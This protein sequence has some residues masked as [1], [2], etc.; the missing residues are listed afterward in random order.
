VDHP[1]PWLKYVDAGDLS[2]AVVDFEGMDVESPDGEGLGDVE[3]FIVDQDNGRPY[4]VVVNS[5][6]WFKSK[7]FLLPVGHTRLQSDEG[8]EMLVAGISRERIKRFPGFDK[9]TFEKL[10]PEDLKRFNDDT[11]AACGSITVTYVETEPYTAAWDRADYSHPTWW[12]AEQSF[13][14][15]APASDSDSAFDGR[16][17][18]GD[19]VGIETDGERTYIGDT[20][21]DELKRREDAEKAAAKRT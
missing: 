14:G 7:H 8:G 18:P 13:G 1:Y 12:S 10:S 11:C 6:G 3:G 19:V 15:R 17:Q 5:K 21:E 4:Y 16:A 9:S 20:A 2:G